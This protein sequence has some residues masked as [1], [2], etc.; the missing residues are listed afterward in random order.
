M[1]YLRN[2]TSAGPLRLG[3]H[4]DFEENFGKP[5]L[6]IVLGLKATF[7]RGRFLNF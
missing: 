7:G 3:R 6:N 2:L 1:A 4:L 5:L